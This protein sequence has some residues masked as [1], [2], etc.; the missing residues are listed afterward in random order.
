MKVEVFITAP[1]LILEGRMRSGHLQLRF[2]ASCQHGS[3]IRGGRTLI[4]WFS[5]SLVRARHLVS[6]AKWPKFA[7]RSGV[8]KYI[9]TNKNIPNLGIPWTLEAYCVHTLPG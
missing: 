3:K 4:H 7:C 9:N 8:R 2:E 5:G 6:Q 1:K